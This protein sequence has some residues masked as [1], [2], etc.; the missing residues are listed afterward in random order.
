ML[1]TIP[2]DDDIS[3]RRARAD[4]ALA[5]AVHLLEIF[6]LFA[7]VGLVDSANALQ[8]IGLLRVGRRRA[9][10]TAT[11]RGLRDRDNPDYS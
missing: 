1:S 6:G 2:P 4:A 8:E 7:L 10:G 3:E 9:S 5:A 11:R